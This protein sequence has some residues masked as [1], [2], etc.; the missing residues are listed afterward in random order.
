M[1]VAAGL[2]AVL[3]QSLADFN[4]HLIPH[5]TLFWADLGLV[6]GLSGSSLWGITP[7][8]DGPASASVRP[9]HRQKGGQRPAPRPGRTKARGRPSE[10]IPWRLWGMT[11]VCVGLIPFQAASY[12]ADGYGRRGKTAR[13]AGGLATSIMAYEQALTFKPFSAPLHVALSGAYEAQYQKTR[14]TD[15]LRQAIQEYERAIACNP[16]FAPYYGNFGRLLLTYRD[17]LTSQDIDRAMALLNQGVSLNPFFWGI[18][19]NLGVVYYLKRSFVDAE[20]AYQRAIELSPETPDVYHNLG[21]LY[22]AIGR[23]SD[24]ETAFRRT[25]ELKPDNIESW[26][27]L[28]S[29]Y[30]ETRR[31]DQA[32]QCF[33]RVIL[34]DRQSPGVYQNLGNCYL[35]TGRLDAAKLY[36]ETVLKLDPGNR[37][38]SSLLHQVQERMSRTQ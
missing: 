1:G 18:H 13:Q 24:A 15:T 5:A 2:I 16:Y 21:T 28:G 32:I 25:V 11:I 17:R 9:L 22:R 38:V 33:N 12:L 31:Y 27:S 14:R 29:L 23:V 35:M 26:N 34:K 10:R 3:V 36:Y 4:L 6:A 30:Y 37:D 8:T 20:R 7:S 19:N